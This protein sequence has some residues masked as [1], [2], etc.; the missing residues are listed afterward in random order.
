V[1]CGLWVRVSKFVSFLLR[2]DPGGL[3]MDEE[4]FVDLDELVSK[5]KQCILRVRGRRERVSTS[6]EFFFQSESWTFQFATRALFLVLYG[7]L[8]SVFAVLACACMLVSV[9]MQHS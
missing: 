7:V 8:G 3:V 5:V 2:H 1:E 9:E 6:L 4:G